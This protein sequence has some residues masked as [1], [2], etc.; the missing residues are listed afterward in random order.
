MGSALCGSESNVPFYDMCPLMIRLPVSNFAMKR[1]HLKLPIE[2]RL[3]VDS[4][5]LTPLVVQIL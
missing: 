4:T 3:S 1:R 5:I 2:M